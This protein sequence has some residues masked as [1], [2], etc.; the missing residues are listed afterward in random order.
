MPLPDYACFLLARFRGGQIL[1][2]SRFFYF[3]LLFWLPCF[4]WTTSSGL[5]FSKEMSVL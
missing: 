1:L 5:L 2:P 3:S 4:K